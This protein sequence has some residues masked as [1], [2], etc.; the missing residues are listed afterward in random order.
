M[1]G[2]FPHAAVPPGRC[3]RCAFPPEACLCPEIPRLSTRW[4][5]VILR[6]ASEIPRMTNSGRWVALALTGSVLHDHARDGLPA[7]EEG[8]QALIGEAPAALLFPSPHAPARPDDGLRTLVV[9]DATWSQARRM[10]QRLG[11]LRTLPRLSLAPGPA[12]ARMREPTVAGGMSTLE[13]V[14]ASL[15]LLGDA[16]AAASLRRLHQVAVERTLRLKGM[17]PPGRQRHPPYLP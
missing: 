2:P 13:A 12:A 9:P 6:H 11:P 4:R 8:L 10:V 5:F 7:S 14:A 3:P 15:D 17:W 16:A 1:G